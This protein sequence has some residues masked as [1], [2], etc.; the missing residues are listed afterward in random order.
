VGLIPYKNE[1]YLDW[2]DQANVE[3]LRAALKEV[4]NSLGESYP[5]IIGGKP[6]ETDGEIVSVNP[7][8]PSQ[9]VG[10]VA[11]ATEREADM[12]LET[13]TREFESWSRTAPEARA[14]IML[15]A[16]AIMRRRK[17]EMLAWE[18]HEGGKPWAEAD[19]QVAEA[20]D[21]L[22]YYSRE[23]LRLKDGVEIYSI[24]GEESR[25][26][27]QPMGVGVIIAPWNF[28]TA[29]LT[30]MSSAALVTGNTIIMKPSEFT[31]VI[32]CQVARI[33]EEAGLPEGVLN[34]LPGYG[35]EIG[36]YLV[37]D[38]RTR[39]ISFTGSMKTGLRINELAAKQIENQRWVKRV[40]TEMGGKDAMVIDD[41]ADL[42]AAA[43]DIVK[44]AY[45]YSGQKCSAASRAILH[46]D[47]YD[48]VLN[49]VVEKARELKVGV[50]ESAEVNMGPVI[51][52]PQF[53]KVSGYLEVGKD[54]GERVLGEDPGDPHN[55]YFIAPTI[56]GGVDPKARVAQEEIFGPVL[57]V[58]GARDFD[59]A[60]RIAN[61][62]PYGLTGGVYSKNRDHLERA[63]RE[64]K[65]GNVYFN[66]GITGALVG[67]QP[68]GGYGLSG[69]D[70]KAGGPD[71]LPLHMLARTVV[72]R[73]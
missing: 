53:E 73:F 39:F 44:S 19:A 51:S 63:R 32:A 17:F 62:N 41:S 24:P 45:G 10:R 21:F 26:F 38:A 43:S 47:I 29:I 20:I 27:Y 16:A 67:V 1:P 31:S 58:I 64:F 37:S 25:Y 7:A 52:E 22:E 55:G 50:P 4:G 69:T 13:A 72:E 48:E 14:R 60:L 70:S 56:F 28:P 33:F 6:I 65:A 11:A 34:F 15:R 57:S 8:D 66:R 61:D 46:Q 35:S 54:E 5:L 9:V 3:A 49:K 18:V 40:I 59:E 30:G 42:D 36:D 12:A 68:F 71:Y 23:M 2:T